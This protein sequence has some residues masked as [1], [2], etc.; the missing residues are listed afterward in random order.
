MQQKILMT[1]FEKFIVVKNFKEK[2][3]E[4]SFFYAIG[5]CKTENKSWTCRN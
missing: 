1:L 4:F 5:I 2:Y 3:K